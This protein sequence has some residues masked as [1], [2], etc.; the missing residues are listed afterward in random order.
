[1]PSPQLVIKTEKNKMVAH[2][3]KE[4]G[5]HFFINLNA[6]IYYSIH[7]AVT[8]VKSIAAP[9]AAPRQSKDHRRFY[10]LF[11]GNNHFMDFISFHFN[12][13][14]SFFSD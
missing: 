10:F 2:I 7:N 14:P 13:L 12:D 5:Y 6:R 9:T 11:C 1:M 3:A 8:L 4:M